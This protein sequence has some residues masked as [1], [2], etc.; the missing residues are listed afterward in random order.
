MTIALSHEYTASNYADRF[1]LVKSPGGIEAYLLEDYSSPIISLSFSIAGGD[2][3]DPAGKTGSANM[4]AS[5]LTAGAGDFNRTDFNLAL[6]D[7]AI[8]FGVSVAG[9]SVV[10]Q[11]RMLVEH[12]DRAFELAGLAL[13]QPRLDVSEIEQ[14]RAQRKAQLLAL[15][16]HPMMRAMMATNQL[17]F[18]G[19]AFGRSFDDSC[20]HL[21]AISGDDLRALH[22][23]LI[24]RS[25]LAI[26]VSGAIT[27][28]D[29]GN[30]LDVMFGS[31]PEP[32][33]EIDWP[34]TSA[35]VGETIGIR[36]P[37]Q[38]TAIS[39]M[40][41]GLGIHDPELVGGAIITYT[42][43]GDMRSRL[44]QELREKR[45]LCYSVQ[46][47]QNIV[48]RYFYLSCITMMP[49][50]NVPIAL[51]IIKSEFE[52]LA[53][54]SLTDTEIDTA[55]RYLIGSYAMRF[56][57]TESIANSL[58]ALRAEGRPLTWLDERNQRI[59]NTTSADVRR[60]VDRLIGDGQLGFV[61]AGGVIGHQ[62]N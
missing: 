14:Q 31:L 42:M 10:G 15:G 59:A 24:R 28:A 32:S 50:A 53:Q 35:G 46:A 58:R 13:S 36:L 41:P 30:A 61:F 21:G 22:K 51:P 34:S 7:K 29:L 33:L 39:F 54:E 37:T 44:I 9:S 1:Q 20:K 17:A 19:T 48:Y 2:A 3:L 57:T 18:K 27:A 5:L 43:A 12:R 11:L 25:D 38:D 16:T 8:Q 60:A 40:R 55:R 56:D 6:G 4:L 49:N 23:V 62:G 26:G 47:S 45:G 52:K